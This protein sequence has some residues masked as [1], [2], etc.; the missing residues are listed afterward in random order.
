VEK[1]KKM[2]KPMSDFRFRAMAFLF[3]VRDL[4]RPRENILA[5]VELEPNLH[6]LDF[7]CGPGSYTLLAAQQVG[8]TGKVYALDIQPTAIKYVQE[9][10]QKRGLTNIET[11]RSDCATGLAD[12]SIDVVLLYDKSGIQI[13]AISRKGDKKPCSCVVQRVTAPREKVY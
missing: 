2:D 12:E 5:E 1:E 6:V 10:A 9:A 7:G 4:I 13:A 11:I 8:A 3:Q